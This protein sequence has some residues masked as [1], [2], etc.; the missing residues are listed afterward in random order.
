MKKIPPHSKKK[1]IKV[2]QTRAIYSLVLE[3]VATVAGAFI[4]LWLRHNQGYS[5]WIAAGA[6]FLVWIIFTI[7]AY[8]IL[9]RWVRYG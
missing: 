2:D 9:R 8:T 1:G 7:I 6:A 5:V 4:Y 3:I